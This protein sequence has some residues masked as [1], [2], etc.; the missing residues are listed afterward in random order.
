MRSISEGNV[1]ILI[2][3]C[4]ACSLN[5]GLARSI[6][7]DLPTPSGL[8]ACR[9]EDPFARYLS[10]TLIMFGDPIGCFLSVDRIKLHGVR[11]DISQ[12]IETA[13]A[14][15]ISPSLG[16]YTAGDLDAMY[17]KVSGQWKNYKP[18]NHQVR[19]EYERAVN[20]LIAGGLPKDAPSV[21]VKLEPP[22]LVSIERFGNGSYMVVSI[23]QR[24]IELPN[25]SVVSTAVD[26]TAIIIRNGALIRLSIARELKHPTDISIVHDDTAAW[27]SQMA[28]R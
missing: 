16:P 23:R 9:P 2:G 24:R 7:L 14:I 27:L 4:F 11:S 19:P 18:L 12:P 26:S 3:L 5:V 17:A 20:A 21:R 8:Q 1:R 15:N 25:D 28:A 10:K 13:F 6:R 22:S